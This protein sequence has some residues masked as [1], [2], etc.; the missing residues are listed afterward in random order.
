MAET[1]EHGSLKQALKRRR[2]ASGSGPAALWQN[3]ADHVFLYGK[4][5]KNGERWDDPRWAIEKNL[6]V[7]DN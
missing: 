1:A 7:T 6:W 3:A 2:N 5:S 4:E